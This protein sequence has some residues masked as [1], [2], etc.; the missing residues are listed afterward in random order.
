[1]ARH[2][3][4][5]IQRSSSTLSRRNC[6]Q[7]VTLSALTLS[8]CKILTSGL[9][10]EGPKGLQ[11]ASMSLRSPVGDLPTIEKMTKRRKDWFLLGSRSLEQENMYGK[12]SHFHAACSRWRFAGWRH[13]GSCAQHRVKA[14]SALPLGC[15]LAP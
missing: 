8:K 12:H 13:A 1:M 4:C 3:T 14:A 9:W 2:M 7:V 15:S 11:R 6:L 10:S 5:S